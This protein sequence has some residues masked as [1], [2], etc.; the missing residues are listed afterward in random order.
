MNEPQK[1]NPAREMLEAMHADIRRIQSALL[2]PNGSTPAG[3]QKEDPA[4]QLLS[5]ILT[6][7]QDLQTS[8]EKL[9]QRLD[10]VARYIPAASR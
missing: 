8:Q 2:I 4:I 9:H 6:V 5:S 1:P 10:A 3:P 7:A